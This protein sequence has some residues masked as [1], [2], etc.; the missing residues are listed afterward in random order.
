MNIT[1]LEL[2]NFRN[3][4]K[5]IFNN[6]S[7]LNIIIGKNGIG[8]TS[9]IEAIYLGSL[10]KSFKTNNDESLIN[11]NS[12]YFRIKIDYYDE[13]IKKNLEIYYDQNGKKTKINSTIQRRLSDFISQYRVIMVSPDDLKLIKA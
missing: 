11:N 6:F 10:A 7:N 2:N 9:I 3:Y 1:K 8:K 5:K 4:N 12:N 13:L